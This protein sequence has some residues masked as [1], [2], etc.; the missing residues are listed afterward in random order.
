MKCLHSLSLS[1]SLSLISSISQEYGFVPQTFVLPQDLQ[2]LKRTWDD[3]GDKKKWILKPVSDLPASAL[4]AVS[5]RIA[6]ICTWYRNQGGTPVE[7]N[8]QEETHSGAE[9]SHYFNSHI[10]IILS[11]INLLFIQ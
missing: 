10:L 8:P 11:H 1:L 6:C 7:T 2:L 9:V 5:V 4:A 3:G